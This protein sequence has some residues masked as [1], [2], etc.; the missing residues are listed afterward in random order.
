MTRVEESGE[1]TILGTGELFLDSV[2]KVRI[3]LLSV[4]LLCT[5]VIKSII[6]L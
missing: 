1:H 5:Y 4:T 2:M 6:A 3:T